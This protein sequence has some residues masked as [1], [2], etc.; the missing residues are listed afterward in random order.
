MAWT[1]GKFSGRCQGP[2]LSGNCGAFLPKLLAARRGEAAL[3]LDTEAQ[4]RLYH[5]FES[6]SDLRIGI[7]LSGSRYYR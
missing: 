1:V 6:T 7:L 3:R 5:F 2:V 4:T